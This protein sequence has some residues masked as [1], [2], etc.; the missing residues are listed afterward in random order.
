[1][2][3]EEAPGDLPRVQLR[4]KEDRRIRG[5]HCWIYESEIAAAPADLAAGGTALVCDARGEPLG[6]ALWNPRSRI[7][8]R[9]FCR[10][11]RDFAGF[12][13]EA[14]TQA[15]ALRAAFYDRPYYRLIYG[16]SDGFPG[17][18]V[19]RFGALLVAQ[20]ASAAIEPHAGRLAESLLALPG[21]TGLI[22]RRDAAVRTREGLAL[23]EPEIQG[24]MPEKIHVEEGSL[25]FALDPES[26]LKSGWFFDQRESREWVRARAAGRR[27]LDLFCHSGGFALQAAAGGAKAVLGIDRSEEALDLARA[28]ARINDLAER[29]RFQA[30]DLFGGQGASGWPHGEWDLIVLDPPALAKG[31]GDLKSALGAYQHLNLKAISRVAPGGLL[32][33]CSCTHPIEES[34]W[35]GTVLRAVHKAGRQ[36]RILYRGGQGPDHPVLPGMPE[37][38][39]LKVLGL[40]IL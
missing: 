21:V 31:R 20:L 15:L 35:Q 14:L 25:S 24:R 9:L 12:V 6:S 11:A 28:S 29:C 4:P 17:L 3:L 38:R 2:A 26:G 40:Q 13:P 7:R 36:A 5:G 8:A 1:M 23:L 18:T 19:E 27:V 33:T 22:L 10:G 39:Y 32:L 37:T 34:V 16:E 30:L